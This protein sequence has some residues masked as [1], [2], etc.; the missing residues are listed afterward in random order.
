VR[1]AYVIALGVACVPGWLMWALIVGTA[2]AVWAV[3]WA[4]QGGDGR[5]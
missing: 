1:G 3:R 2:A 5:G 4:A